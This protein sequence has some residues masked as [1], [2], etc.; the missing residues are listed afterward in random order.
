MGLNSSSCTNRPRSTEGVRSGALRSVSERFRCRWALLIWLTSSIWKKSH[1]SQAAAPSI[2]S[3]CGYPHTAPQRQ[4]CYLAFQSE[5][6]DWISRCETCVRPG[7]TLTDWLHHSWSWPSD[8][9]DL[10]GGGVNECVL[11]HSYMQLIT[12][13]CLIIVFY[14]ACKCLIPTRMTRK[15]L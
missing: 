15:F 1:L 8:V 7:C 6:C 12:Y 2:C 9:V 3:Q 10:K 14:N 11:A 5:Q 13:Y 4:W